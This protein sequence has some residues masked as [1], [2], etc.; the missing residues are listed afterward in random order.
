MGLNDS[1]AG[2]HTLS[3]AN[4][5]PA[6][7]NGEVGSGAQF[8][9]SN[10][11]LDAALDLSNTNIV[12]VSFWLNWAAFANNDQL[13]FEFT[14]NTNNYDGGFAVNPNSSGGG[15]ASS[16][17]FSTTISDGSGDYS[18]ATFNRPSA[19]AWHFYS[20]TY[21]RSTTTHQVDQT[22]Y[23]DGVNQTAQF[24]SSNAGLGN[25]ANSTLYLMSRAGVHCSAPAL[26]TNFASIEHDFQVPRLDHH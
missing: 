24:A 15:G 6:A 14:P 20:F 3:N 16:G 22:M 8:N 19:A 26:W 7:V 5:L 23:V 18:I 4:Q 25:F 1:T 17:Y 13:A 10:Q 12:T 2:G 11:A 9:G 21:N